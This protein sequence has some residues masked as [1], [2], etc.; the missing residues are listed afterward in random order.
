M[1]RAT[2]RIATIHRSL[3]AISM[4]NL[5]YP[6]NKKIGFNISNI[7]VK[8]LQMLLAGN[9]TLSCASTYCKRLKY[10]N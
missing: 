1:V 7:P 10:I 6:A 3:L 9:A 4:A 8:E 5:R 2:Q